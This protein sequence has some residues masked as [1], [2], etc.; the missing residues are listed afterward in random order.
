MTNIVI[1]LLAATIIWTY[2]VDLTCS[3]WHIPAVIP[4]VLT[5]LITN[6]LLQTSGINVHWV[7]RVLPILGTIGLVL[8]VLEGA[9]DLDLARDKRGLILRALALASIGI[10]LCAGLFGWLAMRMFGLDAFVAVVIAIPFAV[11]SSAVAIPS[12]GALSPHSREFV[13]Y[14]SSISDIIG[15]LVFFAWLPSQGDTGAF[16]R[17]LIGGGVLSLLICLLL[18]GVLFM[19][20]NHIRGHVRFI[21]ILAGL[22]LL[23]ALGKHFHLSTLLLILFFGL[24]LNNARF[25]RRVPQLDAWMVENYEGSVVEFKGIVAE[26]TF[27]VRG[28]FFVLLGVWTPLKA[29]TDWKAWLTALVATALIFVIRRLSLWLFRVDDREVLVWIAPRGLITVLLILSAAEQ[30]SLDPFPPG[31]VMLTVL[32]TCSAV[33]MARPKQPS[34]DSHAATAAIVPAG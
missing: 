20:V 24:M 8:I 4:L 12:S 17:E 34:A 23:Y 14:E 33:L 18:S 15:V 26:V 28:V 19:V 7:D 32:M 10:V 22:F 27:A 2:L 3:R 21:P 5:G 6:G 1:L 13:V 31:A 30:L 16:L 29:L 9:L 25:F 11:I